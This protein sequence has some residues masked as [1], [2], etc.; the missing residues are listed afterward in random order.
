M[1]EKNEMKT[2]IM[3]MVEQKLRWNPQRDFEV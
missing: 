3:M 1:S 2:L